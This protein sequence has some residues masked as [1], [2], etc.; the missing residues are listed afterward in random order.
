MS[1]PENH[2]VGLDQLVRVAMQIRSKCHVLY[3]AGTKQLMFN[4]Q[5][6]IVVKE[7][8]VVL[9]T[10]LATK[11]CAKYNSLPDD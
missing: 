8:E 2:S 10:P 7:G 11:A 9:H 3:S 1:K 5:G 6:Y 4:Y